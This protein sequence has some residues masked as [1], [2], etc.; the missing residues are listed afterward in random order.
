MNLAK[1]AFTDVTDAELA[2]AT[3]VIKHETVQ[4]ILRAGKFPLSSKHRTT[5]IGALTECGYTSIQVDL[6]E[7]VTNPDAMVDFEVALAV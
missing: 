7:R 4:K 5:L 2:I 6:D 1:L 3:N